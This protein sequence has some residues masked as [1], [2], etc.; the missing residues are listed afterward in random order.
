MGA[1]GRTFLAGAAK[2]LK[3][4]GRGIPKTAPGFQL[5]G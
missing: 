4:E 5:A 1:L 3:S 2:L